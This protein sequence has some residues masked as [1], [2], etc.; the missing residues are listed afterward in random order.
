MLWFRRP[1]R[2]TKKRVMGFVDE[3]V[4]EG[5]HT[6]EIGNHVEEEQMRAQQEEEIARALIEEE[7]QHQ[8]AQEEDVMHRKLQDEERMREIY[9]HEAPAREPSRPLPSRRASSRSMLDD[10]SLPDLLLKAFK[11]AMRDKKIVAICVL[12]VI[13]LLLVL[14]PGSSPPKHSQVI[15]TDS[16]PVA[17]VMMDAG[18]EPV[19]HRIEMATEVPQVTENVVKEARRGGPMEVQETAA[20]EIPITETEIK[21][22][23]MPEI[24]S[25]QLPVVEAIVDS[26]SNE[27]LRSGEIPEL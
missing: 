9:G 27:D 25:T 5:G 16:S 1:G 14:R 8:R 23:E 18:K 17:D 19:R 6:Q 13:V 2:C 24:R 15:M 21:E 11:V 3:E 26:I 10:D 4:H 22:V 12:S 7:K 20:N